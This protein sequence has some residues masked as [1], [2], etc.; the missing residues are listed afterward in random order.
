LLLL[1]ATPNCP[2]PRATVIDQVSFPFCSLSARLQSL[3]E[4]DVVA[5]VVA[6]SL[7]ASTSCQP[8]LPVAQDWSSS[9]SSLPGCPLQLPS[10][11]VICRRDSFDRLRAHLIIPTSLLILLLFA[12][13]RGSP[14]LAQ[15]SSLIDAVC[16]S[17]ARLPGMLFI[18]H[19]A[20]LSWARLCFLQSALRLLK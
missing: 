9:V 20:R 12:T 5:V 3:P 17:L 11:P 4:V 16:L 2:P 13:G 10:H 1:L 8:S 18:N 7:L 19:I 6:A 15:L 14:E